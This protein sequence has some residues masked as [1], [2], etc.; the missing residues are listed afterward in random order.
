MTEGGSV[1]SSGCAPP[2]RNTN[3]PGIQTFPELNTLRPLRA[4]GASLDAKG[5]A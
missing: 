3:L 4:C 5:V 1:S 2:L